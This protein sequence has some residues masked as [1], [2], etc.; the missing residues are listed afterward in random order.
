LN[1]FIT[2]SLL[3][4]QDI[5]VTLI[6]L[7]AFVLAGAIK[8]FLGIGLPP[9]AMAILTLVIDTPIAISLLTLPIIFTNLFQYL[10]CQNPV[11]IAK[12]YWLFGLSIMG[13]I[14]LTSLFIMSFPKSI[15]SVTIGFAMVL[16]SLSQMFGT[17]ISFGASSVWHFVFGV[18]AGVLGG[19]SS[20]WSPPVAMYLLARHVSKA[21]FIGATGFLF[22]AGSVPLAI[23]LSFAGVLTIDTMLHSVMGLIF[24]LA[25]FWVGEWLRGHMQQ[26]AFRQIVLWAFFIMGGRLV[27]LGLS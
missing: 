16:F 1:E 27:T 23:G 6:I 14:F 13:S 12:K 7:G 11:E 19:L 15:I 4:S 25:G 26:G 18:F 24:V 3:P 10:G 20:I 5:S 21:E 17:K 22:L 2:I 9:A 8:G